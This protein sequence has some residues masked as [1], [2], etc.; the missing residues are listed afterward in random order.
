MRRVGRLIGWGAAFR[1]DARAQVATIFALSVLPLVTLTGFVIDF[2]RATSLKA[3]I[4]AAA[5]TAVL[6]GVSTK[7][8]EADQQVTI[9]RILRAHLTAGQNT[10]LKTVKVTSARTDLGRRLTVTYTAESKTMLGSLVGPEKLLISSTVSA[11]ASDPAYSD[12]TFVLDKSSS[13]LL[14][15][16]NADRTKMESVTRQMGAEECAFA[17]HRP[18]LY[19][20]AKKA[21]V[22]PSSTDVARNNGVRLRMDVMK[23]AIRKILDDLR[24]E[25]ATLTV[26]PEIPRYLATLVDFGADWKVTQAGNK[27]ISNAKTKA[28]ISTADLQAA[29]TAVGTIDGVEW[30]WSNFPNVWSASSGVPTFPNLQSSG[31]GLGPTTRKKH[32]VFVTDGVADYYNAQNNR[33][34]TTFDPALCTPLKNRKVTVI[35]LYTR[36]YPLPNNAFYMNNVNP[37]YSQIET[38]LRGCASPDMFITA[39]NEA[40]MTLAFKRIFTVL[41]GTRTRLSQ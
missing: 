27:T 31:D 30:E 9:E 21:Y 13:M 40:E 3:E 10:Q 1:R 17:C 22:G 33:V 18:I 12:I 23:D 7:I 28:F 37:W 41:N 19:D 14:A 2:A 36:Y 25:Q 16:S 24:S 38:R 32:L 29:S 35:V 5:D 20:K 15:A 34:I 39:D 4:S 26:H 11:L 8:S 6:A